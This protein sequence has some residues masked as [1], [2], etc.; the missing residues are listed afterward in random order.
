[1]RENWRSIGLSFLLTLV[2][3]SSANAVVLNFDDLAG[4]TNLKNTFYQ[5]VYFTTSSTKL[6]VA[7]DN[8]SGV[9]CSSLHNSIGTSPDLSMGTIKVVFPVLANYVKVTG[10]DAGGD[11]DSFSLEVYD[12]SNLLINSATT[13]V[14][15]GNSLSNNGYY[16]DV[17]NLE[18]AATNI[19]YALLIPTSPSGFGI[20]FDDLTYNAVPLPGTL[21]MVS[22]G[23]LSLVGLRRKF[24]N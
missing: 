2:M 9:G 7:V 13:G 19:A 6:Y 5:G 24:R 23:F 17:A 4:G 1:M 16:G 15:G 20:T 18:L 10:G 12:S 21:L 14:F 3:A 11:L 22:S 8:E